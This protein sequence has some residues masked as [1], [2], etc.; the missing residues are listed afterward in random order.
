MPFRVPDDVRE[1]RGATG[2]RA[3]KD[4]GE[5][6]HAVRLGEVGP[7]D[8]QGKRRL[9][10]PERHVEHLDREAAAAFGVTPEPERRELDPL[11]SVTDRE[12]RE[13]A[14]FQQLQ[15]VAERTLEQGRRRDRR[16]CGET[17][18]RVLGVHSQRP[19]EAL[20]ERCCARARGLRRAR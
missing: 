11:R 1:R 15:L 5:V 20:G 12:E 17:A 19:L 14:L 10:T 2:R 9:G 6:T 4:E 7:Q 3:R 18:R 8:R 16:E 13:N